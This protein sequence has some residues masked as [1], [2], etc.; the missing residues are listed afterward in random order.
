MGIIRALVEARVEPACLFL[1]TT[2]NICPIASLYM[3]YKQQ[4]YQN[5]RYI[6]VTY[7]DKLYQYRFGVNTSMY[8]RNVLPYT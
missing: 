5:Y 8:G 4:H 7:S 3:S 6:S 1:I 2:G